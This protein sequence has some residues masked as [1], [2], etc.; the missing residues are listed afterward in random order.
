[1]RRIV[2]PWPRNS[3]R[4]P[5]LALQRHDIGD[6]PPA[7]LQR[8]EG[9]LEHARIGNA[10][11][12]E[13]GIG[14]RLAGETRPA[15]ALRRSSPAA[16]RGSAG[17]RRCAPPARRAPRKRWR[18]WR[19]WRRHHSS[20]IE[21]EPAPTSQSSCAGLRLQGREGDGADVGLG[22]LAVMREPAIVEPAGKRQ[23]PRI[24]RGLQLQRHEVQRI[25]L[26]QRKI[27]RQRA[28]DRSRGPP[29]ASS[30]VSREAPKPRALKQRRQPGRA[31]SRPRTGP[32]PA[33]RAADAE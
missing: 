12:D 30:T 26:R 16:R 5:R 3:A 28:A 32:A 14:R 31:C 17:W 7:R 29:S 15:P 19:G 27:L 11:A 8:R 21:P 24:R 13:H 25:D 1:M 2:P 18:D 33:G 23:D 22:E 10:T 6:Q 20:E 4:Q 9:R